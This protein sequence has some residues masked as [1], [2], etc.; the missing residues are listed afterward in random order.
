MDR[1]EDD[2]LPEELRELEAGLRGSRTEPTA[3]QLDEL[4]LR[5]MRQAERRQR[6][7]LAGLVARWRSR[8]VA[9]VLA[10][11]LMVSTS[12]GLVVAASGKRPSALS[13]KK[14]VA[15]A[16]K[17]SKD[18]S[19]QQYCQASRDDD[20]DSDSARDRDSDSD[21]DG[22][23]S[24]SDGNDGGGGDSDDDSSDRGRDDSDRDSDDRG[25]SS[26]RD[27]DDGDSDSDTDRD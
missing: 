22:S 9:A 2:H 18:S 3:M 14:M 4:K 11:G 25:G 19:G 8:V 5:A 16:K 7:G 10:I 15:A 6:G 24:H 27:S 23:D 21:C 13:P 20:S 26:D 1:F 12:T 17:P